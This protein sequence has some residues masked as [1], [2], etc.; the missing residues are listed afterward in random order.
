VSE[1]AEEFR[2]RGRRI[3]LSLSASDDEYLRH[4]SRSIARSYEALAHNEEW[5]AGEVAPYAK[6]DVRN[7]KP[8]DR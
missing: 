1:R 4:L 8:L 2:A 3:V 7:R 6:E 5:L